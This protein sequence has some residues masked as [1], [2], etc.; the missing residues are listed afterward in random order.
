MS[1]PREGSRDVGRG[2]VVSIS[3]DVCLTPQGAAMVPVPYSLV[4][5]QDRSPANMANSVRQTGLVT[6]VKH[7]LITQSFGDEPGTGGGVKSGTTG[8]ECEPK[9]YSSTVFAEGRNVVRHDDEWWMNHKNTVGRL[10]Y[11][12]DMGG[13][14]GPPAS[15]TRY[16]MLTGAAG[17]SG[18]AQGEPRVQLAQATTG[19]M[20]DVPGV[21]MP[22]IPAPGRN[23]AIG[24]G[25]AVMQQVDQYRENSA[26]QGAAQRFGLDLSQLE[27]VLGARAYVWGQN[28]A[29]MSYWDVPYSGQGLDSWASG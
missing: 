10:I 18:G 15:N 14:K 20:T 22:A 8:K 28:M 16:A 7:S 25:A 23:T 21:G 27:N 4:A 5:Y 13:Y 1:L 12:D 19:T 24:L 3:P 6:H 17:S 9:T 26:V 11:T 29:P 2:I